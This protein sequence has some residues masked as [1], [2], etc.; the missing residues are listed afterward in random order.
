MVRSSDL[1]GLHGLLYD[2]HPG[3]AFLLGCSVY[4]HHLWFLHPCCYQEETLLLVSHL[5][6][7]QLLEGEDRGALVLWGDGREGGMINGWIKGRKRESEAEREG[8]REEREKEKEREGREVT[9]RERVGVERRERV[10]DGRE[11]IRERGIE[12]RE[13][14]YST[15]MNGGKGVGQKEVE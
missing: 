11:R 7:D 4:L 13:I 10:I 14:I 8:E 3:V 9:W 1:H 12:G 15:K 5:S 2:L 6:N